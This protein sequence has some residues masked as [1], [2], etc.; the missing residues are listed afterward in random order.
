MS[1]TIGTLFILF[2]LLPGLIFRKSFFVIP[3]DKRYAEGNTLSEIANVLIIA[4]LTQWLGFLLLRYHSEEC[5]KAV[6]Q[7]FHFVKGLTFE[8]YKYS[9]LTSEFNKINFHYLIIYQLVL[10]VISALLGFLT[11]SLIRYYKLDRKYRL[12]R[13]GNS[14]YY[15]FSGEAI[16]FPDID[17]NANDI[18]YIFVDVLIQSEGKEIIY[19]GILSDFE[20][21]QNGGLKSIAL[22]GAKRRI[23][24]SSS[25]KLSHEIKKNRTDEQIL[26]DYYTIPSN[27]LIIPYS[28]KILNINFR[29][30]SDNEP[31]KS[32]HDNDDSF[33]KFIQIIS[34][35]IVVILVV[36][37]IILISNA[38]RKMKK[39]KE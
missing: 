10:W 2:F 16:E 15:Y 6:N 9:K 29:Y 22:K 30:Y 28:E 7:F 36:T 4:I 27:H 20:L 14:W 33:V 23:L 5:F 17:G 37:A 34:L 25:E 31:D 39:N 19:V 38:V 21:S 3:F 8:T 32:G 35:A 1:I 13:F 12:F 11:T 26:E 18:D 24:G